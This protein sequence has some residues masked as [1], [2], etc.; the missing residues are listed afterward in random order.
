MHTQDTVKS[1][2]VVLLIGIVLSLYG[3]SGATADKPTTA[4]PDRLQ[5]A[6]RI[7]QRKIEKWLTSPEGPSEA[8]YELV[9]AATEEGAATAKKLLADYRASARDS[10]LKKLEMLSYGSIA[11]AVPVHLSNDAPNKWRGAVSTAQQSV[12][13]PMMVLFRG[14]DRRDVDWGHLV[15]IAL[16]DEDAATLNDVRILSLFTTPK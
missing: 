4:G 13:L 5:T 12:L 3:C 14:H 15:V 7:V 16:V 6:A 1:A 11:S 2:M 8:E 10:G 9:G